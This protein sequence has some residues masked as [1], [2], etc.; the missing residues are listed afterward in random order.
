M[1]ILPRF[2]PTKCIITL[3]NIWLIVI[4]CQRIQND[5]KTIIYKGVLETF[6]KKTLLGLLLY[7]FYK[8]SEITTKITKS[9][10]L[11]RF[12]WSQ[13]MLCAFLYGIRGLEIRIHSREQK[14]FRSARR[15]NPPSRRFDSEKLIYLWVIFKL[16]NKQSSL[17][18]TKRKKMQ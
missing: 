6:F 9:I 3:S 5:T 15:N 8:N 17:W 13:I 1:N 4:Q 12:L 7:I 14:Y 16:Y 18:S 10:K 11:L 2:V